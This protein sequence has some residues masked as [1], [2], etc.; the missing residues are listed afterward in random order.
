MCECVVG[1]VAG[2][3]M[4]TIWGGLSYLAYRFLG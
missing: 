1:L 3:F 2:V 4:V